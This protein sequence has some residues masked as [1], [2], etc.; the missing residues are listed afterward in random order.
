MSGWTAEPYGAAAARR[1][2]PETA[3]GG[4]RAR[5]ASALAWLRARRERRRLYNQTVRELSQLSDRDLDDI[6]I[7]RW[8]IREIAAQHTRERLGR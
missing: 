3:D 8:D 5:V 6:G 7:S 2:H 1:G 4:L